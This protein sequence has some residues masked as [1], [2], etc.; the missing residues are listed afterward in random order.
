M[1]L[2]DPCLR[3][4]NKTALLATDAGSCQLLLIS[5]KERLY[6]ALRAH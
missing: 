5:H 4:L 3:A 1:H 6:I 2:A